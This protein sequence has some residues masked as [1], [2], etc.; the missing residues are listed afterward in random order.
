M[1]LISVFGVSFCTDLLVEEHRAELERWLGSFACRTDFG[2]AVTWLTP[3]RVVDDDARRAALRILGAHGAMEL[4][5][6]TVDV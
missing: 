4:R 6:P 2:E 1:P 5:S 3:D